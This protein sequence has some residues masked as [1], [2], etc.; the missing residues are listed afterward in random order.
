[1]Y[2]RGLENEY[3]VKAPANRTL[4]LVSLV[5][6]TLGVLIFLFISA[7]PSVQATKT[8]ELSACVNNETNQVRIVV[9]QQKCRKS[10]RTIPL[11]MTTTQP[12][13]A[14]R[15]GVGSPSASLGYDGDFYVDTGTYTFF[16]PRTVGNWGVGQSLIGPPGPQGS[17]GILGPPGETGPTGPVGNTGP[18]GETGPVGNTGPPGETGP[19]GGFGDYGSFLDTETRPLAQASAY[20][21]P[22]NV[23][24][25]AQGVSV[26]SGSQ[27]TMTNPG[28][29]SIAF[30]LQ[31]FNSLNTRPVVTI[32]LNKNDSP[33]ADSATD[34][35]L[36]T[37]IDTERSVAAWNFFVDAEA[38]D[39][40]SIMVLTN[41]TGVSVYG[42]PAANSGAPAIPSTILTVNQ[43]G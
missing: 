36:G 14:I 16:G 3:P 8:Y 15:Y 18:P 1:M 42:G 37:S 20:A 28:K 23:T 24:Q 17:A 22:L 12:T 9:A 27:I 39:Y 29:Y 19:A 7:T 32:W 5:A 30:S 25:F 21:I 4:A 38:G 10:E 34:V 41:G 11:N 31:L 33:V 43:V 35:Y 2:P 6:L 40:F 13:P 26:V